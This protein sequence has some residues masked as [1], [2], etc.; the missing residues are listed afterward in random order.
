[1][2]SPT[3]PPT[4][5][6]RN[7]SVVGAL[8]ATKDL[9]ITWSAAIER[10]VGD[11]YT[12]NVVVAA[13]GALRT[14]PLRPRDLEPIT[15]RHSAS[16]TRLVDRLEDHGDVRRRDAGL[17]SDHRAVLVRITRQ[18]R[19]AIDGVAAAIVEHAD[20]IRASLTTALAHL[21][22]FEVAPSRASEVGSSPVEVCTTLGRLGI[23]IAERLTDALDGLDMNAAVALCLL[24]DD[25]NARPSAL[26][27]RLGLTSGGTTKL[28]D[29]LESQ[30]LIVRSYGRLHSDRRAVGVA[31]TPAGAERL[32]RFLT[33]IRPQA[34]ELFAVYSVI[35]RDLASLSMAS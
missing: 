31:L 26:A 12:D 33:S 27:D 25:P 9:S 20:E 6:R 5:T 32:D 35:E 23:V 10:S 19:H 22:R 30:G 24:V 15:H 28:L 21:D 8:L 16:V 17:A 14:G 1:M 2:A 18:G 13:L 29:R 4:V 7:R 34:A 3:T 11:F